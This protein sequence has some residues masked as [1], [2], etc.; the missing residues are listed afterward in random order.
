[1]SQ[2]ANGPLDLN[3]PSA[4][5][6]VAR[7]R[8]AR[9]HLK[10]EIPGERGLPKRSVPEVTFRRTG[11][12]GDFNRYRHEEKHDD[13][14]M[15]I[16]IVPQETIEQLGR[17]GWPVHPGDLG[18]NVT[19]VGIPYDEFRPGRGFG[20]GAA[21]VTITKACTPCTFLYL[22]PY[23]GEKRGPEFVRTMID[24]RGWY[25]RV[26]TEGAVR[27]GDPIRPID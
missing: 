11:V 22:L 19:T 16:L 27:V 25:A 6:P 3:S 12:V 15:A 21:A 7:G 4:V 8:V 17:E 1:M 13:E 5:N 24:R 18:E 2:N 9:L 14:G 26:V 20:I 23:V 10:P